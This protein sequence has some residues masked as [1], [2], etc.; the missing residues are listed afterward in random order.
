MNKES[1]Q[2]TTEYILLLSIVVLI[3]TLVSTGLKNAGV[4]GLLTKPITGPFAA[5]YQFGR[6]DA[7]GWDNGSSPE[8]HPRADSGTGNFRI[9]LGSAAAQ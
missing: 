5:A 1:G 4:A 6:A 7:K 3:F 9:F 8:N 2:A